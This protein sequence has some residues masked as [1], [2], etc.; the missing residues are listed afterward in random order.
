MMDTLVDTLR[1][2]PVKDLAVSSSVIGLSFVE[3]LPFWLRMATML[4]TVIY[5]A[6]KAWNEIKK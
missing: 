2:I 1:T 5:M 6:A 3:W 4:F